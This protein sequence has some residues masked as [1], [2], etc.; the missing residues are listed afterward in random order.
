[1]FGGLHLGS[2]SVH[3]VVLEPD[4]RVLAADRARFSRP[5][6]MMSAVTDLV[7]ALE[8]RASQ[9]GKPLWSLALEKPQRVVLA[10]RRVELP[11]I[12]FKP[13]IVQPALSAVILGAIPSNPGLLL[14]LGREVRF[15]VVD[16][17]HTYREYRVVE[18]G[19][20]WWQAEL[21][22]LA[23]YS[24][25]LTTHLSAYP[26]SVPP[27]ARIPQLL[28]LGQP[29]SPDAVL[30]PRLEKIATKL[31][32][33]AVTL[34]ARLPDLQRFALSGYLAPSSLG[35][36]ISEGLTGRLKQVNPA[37]PPEVGAA[38][39]PLAYERENWEREHLGKPRF[40]PDRTV[41]DWA[42]PKELVRRLFRMRKPFEQYRR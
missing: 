38:L 39:I 4:G 5:E 23:V 41:D 8:E 18:G 34:T 11:T 32:E 37:F 33:M 2:N 15:A 13:L 26:D 10:P 21:G 20:T 35:S 3:A 16:S 29:P 6:E 42:P 24:Q 27:L 7:A 22:R 9:E 19:G 31:V 1:M 14:S 30:K 12:D 25:R 17:T 36:L 40:E 28:D